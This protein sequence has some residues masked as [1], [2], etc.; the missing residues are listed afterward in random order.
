METEK[1]IY[2]SSG[3]KPDIKFRIKIY[4]VVGN[5]LHLDDAIGVLCTGDANI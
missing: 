3:H 1:K 2:Y 4:V 5:R